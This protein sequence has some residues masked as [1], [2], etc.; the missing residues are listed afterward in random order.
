MR[1]TNIKDQLRNIV[2]DFHLFFARG[3]ISQI[4]PEATIE[5]F[6]VIIYSIR[7]LRLK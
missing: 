5:I 4:L 7:G 2:T 6:V 3:K 1:L